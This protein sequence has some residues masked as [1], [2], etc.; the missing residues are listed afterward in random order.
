VKLADPTIRLL[1]LGAGV[2]STVLAL[3]AAS[4]ELLGLDGAVFADTGWEP[5]RVVTAHE[6]A[7]RQV[8][9]F[10]AIADQALEDGD[11]DGCSPYGCR[12]G[13][14]VTGGH[15]RLADNDQR[16]A[17]GMQAPLDLWEAA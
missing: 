12:S 14:P 3:M 13:L 16:L 5:R 15:V 17:L 2:Q 6:W 7:Q 4:G 1:S 8:D 9:I 10:D 11:V